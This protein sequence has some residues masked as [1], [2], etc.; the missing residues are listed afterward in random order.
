MSGLISN[1]RSPLVRTI[2]CGAFVVV[3]PGCSAFKEK[4]DMRCDKVQT[5]IEMHEGEKWHTQ[6]DE[7]ETVVNAE[8]YRQ[9]EA[10]GNFKFLGTQLQF[11]L[12]VA[13]KEDAQVE[14][15]VDYC[16]EK[17]KPR[18]QRRVAQAR[19]RT[20]GVIAGA[21][22]LSVEARELFKQLSIPTGQILKERMEAPP[23]KAPPG[24]T[25]TGDVPANAT[26]AINRY[27]RDKE[28]YLSIDRLALPESGKEIG[29]LLV[30]ENLNCQPPGQDSN[31]TWP[32]STLGKRIFELPGDSVLKTC[33]AKAP[34]ISYTYGTSLVGVVDDRYCLAIGVLEQ[35]PYD[36]MN[37]S[38]ATNINRDVL[39]ID[40]FC[41]EHQGPIA[42]GVIVGGPKQNYRAPDGSDL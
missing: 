23:C 9:L 24:V 25:S 20:L 2:L 39:E 18:K 4:L 37:E 35:K 28:A 42:P 40:L 8:A 3:M 10:L 14:E 16:K 31:N 27:F 21:E 7:A 6:V 41:H 17:L 22:S 36:N 29:L 38:K 30:N 5:R 34:N 12:G 1:L 11:E 32:C 19:A 15:P 26:L 13:P 33:V